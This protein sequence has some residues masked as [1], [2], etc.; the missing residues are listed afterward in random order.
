MSAMSAKLFN[1]LQ[2]APFYM[3]LHRQAVQLLPIGDQKSWIDVGCGPGLVT[4]FA[5]QHGY[6]ALGIDPSVASITMATVIAENLAQSPSQFKAQFRVADLSELTQLASNKLGAADVISACSLLAVLPDRA[7]ALMQLWAA[8]KPNGYLLIVEPSSQMRLR[9]AWS[10]LH[11]IPK[12][13]RCALLLWSWARQNNI[14]DESIFQ[15]LNH[16]EIR[17]YSLL[18][19]LVRAWVIRK[20]KRL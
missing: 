8:V 5:A 20:E 3:D 16:A 15:R 6:H 10:C 13:R 18:F 4:R 12:K 11:Q 14:V 2:A 9:N 1:W 17:T 7:Q 19:G